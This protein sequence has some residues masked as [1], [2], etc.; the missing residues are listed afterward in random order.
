MRSSLS[1]IVL[2]LI[3]ASRVL[4]IASITAATTLISIIGSILIALIA[5]ISSAAA[6]AAAAL[7]SLI[8]V[9]LIVLS[10]SALI[11]EALTLIIVVI[12]S[13]IVAIVTLIAALISTLIALVSALIEALIIVAASSRSSTPTVAASIA[14]ITL[15]VSTLI[16]LL[17]SALIALLISLILWIAS[18]AIVLRSEAILV[19]ILIGTPLSCDI[20]GGSANRTD[21]NERTMMSQRSASIGA[22]H[23]HVGIRTRS[24]NTRIEKSSFEDETVLSEVADGLNLIVENSEVPRL[25]RLIRQDERSLVRNSV[26]SRP[27][28]LN[29]ELNEHEFARNQG[30]PILKSEGFHVV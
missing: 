14:L 1:T 4:S 23:A 15:L 18:C 16:A 19:G 17:I 26:L 24:S 8:L 28:A 12:V 13:L 30:K 11:V 29:S 2:P 10:I 20:D 22:R 3:S 25:L 7:I 5:R 21:A 6:A 9:I 27:S